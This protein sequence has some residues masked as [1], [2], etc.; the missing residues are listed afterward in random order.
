MNK[1]ET[2]ID[3]KAA[4]QYL[5]PLVKFIIFLFKYLKSVN[6]VRKTQTKVSYEIYDDYMLFSSNNINGKVEERQV[7]YD[8][9]VSYRESKDY[10]FLILTNNN[11][12]IMSK[13]EISTKLIKDKGYI[14][15]RT[16]TV[17]R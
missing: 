5:F 4:K 9:I 8:E 1:I 14:K 13:N 17:K 6:I 12:F 3:V 2:T 10:Y 15:T 7:S 11:A 16:I